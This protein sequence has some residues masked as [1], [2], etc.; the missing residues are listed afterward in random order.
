M[1]RHGIVF[2]CMFALSLAFLGGCS[3]DGDAGQED[4][5]DSLQEEIAYE[6]I[7]VN[8]TISSPAADDAVSVLGFK[9]QLISGATVLDTLNAV[10]LPVVTTENADGFME[11]ER[12]GDLSNSSDA[13]WSYAVN[14]EPKSEPPS[15]VVLDDG[16]SIVWTF[17]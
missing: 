13:K 6:T 8:I 10:D 1:K 15:I 11:I 12:I 16:D 5:T 3:A 4:D 9:T 2:I 14:G 7:G 17:E